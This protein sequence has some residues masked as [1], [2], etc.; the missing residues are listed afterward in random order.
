MTRG[1]IG[2]VVVGSVAVAVG[3][4]GWMRWRADD[5]PELR[6]PRDVAVADDGTIYVA[7]R[8]SHRV[9]AVHDGDLEVAVGNGADARDDG[10]GNDDHRMDGERAVDVAL[11]LPDAVAVVGDTLYV[12]DSGLAK[13]LRVDDGTVHE[14]DGTWVKPRLL[15]PAPDGALYVLDTG[16]R[17]VSADGDIQASAA[18]DRLDVPE[19]I[20]NGLQVTTDGTVLVWDGLD[21]LVALP[22]SGPADVIVANHQ[23]GVVDIGVGP[24]QTIALADFGR[25]RV[26]RVDM[27]GKTLTQEPLGFSPRAVAFDNHDRIVVLRWADTTGRWLYT[28]DRKGSVHPLLR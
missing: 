2:V 14:L 17:R 19:T 13:V 15:A 28:I 4:I 22:A 1:R 11:A 8:G 3:V 7:D 26:T 6:D 5:S 16:L 27:N 12:A 25:D 20:V 9:F 21:G 18:F 10:E 23:P 24:D